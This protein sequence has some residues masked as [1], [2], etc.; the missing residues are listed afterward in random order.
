MGWRGKLIPH[1]AGKVS[2]WRCAAEKTSNPDIARVGG[3]PYKALWSAAVGM[4][5][6]ALD[7]AGKGCLG[8][9]RLRIASLACFAANLLKGAKTHRRYLAVFIFQGLGHTAHERA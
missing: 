6:Q 2:R 7:N 8:R 5:P 1:A 4:R 3:L 9:A